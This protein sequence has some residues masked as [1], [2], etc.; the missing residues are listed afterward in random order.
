MTFL[1]IDYTAGAIWTN[2]MPDKLAQ[3]LPFITQQERDTLYNNISFVLAF[4]RGHP[5]REG[6][7]Q[8]KALC[9]SLLIPS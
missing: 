4:E 7:I 1:T 3:Y 5:V 6:V 2:V 8:G 9:M